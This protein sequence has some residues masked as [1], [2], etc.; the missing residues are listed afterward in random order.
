MVAMTSPYILT[1]A[2]L[3]VLL[4][5]YK[6]INLYRYRRE[7]KLTG[8][9]YVITPFLE[10]EIVALLATPLLR[11]LYHKHLDRGTGWPA[12]CRFFIKDWQWEDKRLAHEA[13]GDTFLCVSPE[14]IICYTADAS[15]AWDVMN[16]RND[17]TKPRDKYSI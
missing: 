9:P 3:F 4:I 13:Y 8:L 11:R 5:L 7:A 10:T 6:V 12:W 16:R 1:L 15:I 17:F 14:G 2:P